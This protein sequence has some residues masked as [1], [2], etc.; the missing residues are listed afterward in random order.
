MRDLDTRPLHYFQLVKSV[1]LYQ[2]ELTARKK[3]PGREARI[4]HESI[5][6]RTRVE[7]ATG[8]HDSPLHYQGAIIKGK[9]LSELKLCLFYSATQ[10]LSHILFQKNQSFIKLILCEDVRGVNWGKSLITSP[11]WNKY[12]FRT[13]VRRRNW[14]EHLEQRINR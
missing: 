7:A 4:Y 10:K 11:N 9:F 3:R 13:K 1:V 14:K 2:A 5:I 6:F 12:G 8:L